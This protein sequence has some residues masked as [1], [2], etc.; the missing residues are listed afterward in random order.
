[1]ITPLNEDLNIIAALD[2][3][4]NDEGGLTSAAFKAKFDEG[5]NAIKTYLNNTMSP[6]ITSDITAAV[7]AAEIQ[8]GNM[9]AGG[10]AGQ[11]LVKNSDSNY[12]YGWSSSMASKVYADNAAF[13][14][15]W[16]LIQSYVTAGA[17]TFTVPDHYGDGQPYQ[18][19]VYLLGGGGSGGA[20]WTI[21]ANGAAGGGAAG[22]GKNIILT[23]TPGQQITGVVSAGGTAVV[24]S[25]SS[26]Y[27]GGNAG[28]STSFNGVTVAG[29]SGGICGT[30]G[31]GSNGGQGSD[32]FGYDIPMGVY[33]PYGGRATTSI[34]YPPGS[35]IY[36]GG[37]SQSAR[38]C[39]N[40]FDPSMV[41][42]AAGGNGRVY[43]GTPYI[44]TGAT[45]LDNTK[46]GNGA[47]TYSV[48][49]VGGNA[50]GN[51][52]GG[53]GA[54]ATTATGYTATSGSGA[55]GAIFI[56]AKKAVS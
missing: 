40:A 7:A 25:T 14:P 9:P 8:S 23:V 33:S 36:W 34:K 52:N 31:N 32:A 21:N 20:F 41:T 54:V 27:V 43:S 46:G 42:L 17:I 1:M 5:P 22:Y 50:T 37:L 56:Y 26:N 4:P 16:T 13:K 24:A 11:T 18:I 3:E 51:G 29:G 45:L 48:S 2:D 15:L 39:Q 19:G 49:A 44:Q 10:T 53:G 47:A 38:E 12:D 55:P 30:Y 6:N 35:D 28:G